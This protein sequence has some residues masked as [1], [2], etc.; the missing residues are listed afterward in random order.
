MEEHARRKRPWWPVWALGL[1]GL[2]VTAGC[3]HTSESTSSLAE[4]QK[5]VADA[6]RRAA[7]SEQKI[8]AL[9]DKVFLLT[10]Q[11]ESQ[12][13]AA[14]RHSA[15]HES[16][17]LG[18]GDAPRPALAPSAAAVERDD[19]AVHL[20]VVQLRPATTPEPNEL[21]KGDEG[22][23]IPGDEVVFAGEALSS[24]ANHTRLDA[25]SLAVAPSGITPP[26]RAPSTSASKG[27]VPLSP[28]AP[29]G[30]NLGVAPVPPISRAL[31]SNNSAP[32]PA[33]APAPT[34]TNVITDPLRLY[35][36]SYEALRQGR[37]ADAERGF[38]EFLVR[39]P[40]HD[41]ADNAQY[42]LAECFYDR[43]LYAEAAPEFRA[44]VSRYPLGNKA[45]DA[46]LKLAY[47]LLA[48]G[49][50]DKGR[51]ILVQLPTNYPRTEAAHLAEARLRD[52][53][54]VTGGTQ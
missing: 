46:L 43:K 33:P 2:F 24:D 30:D 51:E 34:T 27:S 44:V 49:Q 47:C 13:V 5:R 53:H 40:R 21:A 15:L 45:P 19:D 18:R 54:V 41:Y 52:L 20:P 48:L 7:T 25:A 29:S 3:A 17:T 11:L 12:R 6:D 38:R 28:V 37:H 35:R 9:E 31:A 26:H 10:D 14:S 8:E 4:L 16:H 50:N 22:D 42:W 36:T 32:A 1:G 39:F 23:T